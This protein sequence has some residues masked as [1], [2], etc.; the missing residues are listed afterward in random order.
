ML[1]F[2]SCPRCKGDMYVNHDLY[3]DYKECLQCGRTEEI[4][5]T[6]AMTAMMAAA[7]VTKKRKKVA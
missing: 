7:T 5:K 1:Y 4:E 2:K 3:G 6:D